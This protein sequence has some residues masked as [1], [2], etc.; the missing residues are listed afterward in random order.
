MKQK[1]ICHLHKGPQNT[2]QTYHHEEVP[3]CRTC[4]V[5]SIKIGAEFK[6][7]FYESLTSDRELYDSSN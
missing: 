6:N 5:L 7:G 4:Q 2:H 1:A 3:T